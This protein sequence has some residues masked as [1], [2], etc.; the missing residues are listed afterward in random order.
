PARPGREVRRATGTGE[1][2]LGRR[3]GKGLTG[4][5][6]LDG[7][8]YRDQPVD[9]G[10]RA[11]VVRDRGRGEAEGRIACRVIEPA[12][13]DGDADGDGDAVPQRAGFQQRQGRIADQAG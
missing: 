9:R 7:R 6:D 13:A 12:G 10:Q 8:V 1:V 3:L 5:I 2:A 11:D 4:Q